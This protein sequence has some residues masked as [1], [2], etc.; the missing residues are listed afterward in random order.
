MFLFMS[1]IHCL[2]ASSLDLFMRRKVIYHCP[3][4]LIGSNKSNPKLHITK[5]LNVNPFFS[6]RIPSKEVTGFYV[7]KKLLV[8]AAVGQE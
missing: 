4:N 7:W 6:P 8:M 1:V 5:R 2:H 3:P